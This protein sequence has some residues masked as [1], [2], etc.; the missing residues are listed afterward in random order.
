MENHWWILMSDKMWSF[1]RNI[2]LGTLKVD[3][4][5][6]GYIISLCGPY[7]SLNW[8][9]CGMHR[10]MDG[11]PLLPISPIPALIV[12]VYG[13]YI[14]YNYFL[15]AF[16]F[17][18]NM[19]LLQEAKG[20]R[21]LNPSPYLQIQRGTVA[22]VHIGQV[23]MSIRTKLQNKEHVIKDLCKAKFKS[24]GHQKIHSSKKWGFT[25]FNVNEFENMMAAKQFISD[26]SGVK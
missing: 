6:R 24:S 21:T 23:I 5:S 9:D 17:C 2:T 15:P 10:T 3:Q 12:V 8:L 20:H 22:T 4:I 25:K 18:L 16:Q 7:S 14:L 19:S 1:A 13:T 26:G 11:F